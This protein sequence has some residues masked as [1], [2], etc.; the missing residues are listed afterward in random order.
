MKNRIVVINEVHFLIYKFIIK[1]SSV[2]EVILKFQTT[3]NK[4]PKRLDSGFFES[5]QISAFL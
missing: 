2:L 4:K 5:L 3:M 1:D